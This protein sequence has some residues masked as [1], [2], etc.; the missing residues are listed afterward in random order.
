M[1][2]QLGEQLMLLTEDKKNRV[3]AQNNDLARTLGLGKNLSIPKATEFL[4]FR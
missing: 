1:K 3:Q 2:N 4:L